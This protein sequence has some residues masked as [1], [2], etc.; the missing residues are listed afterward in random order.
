MSMAILSALFLDFERRWFAIETRYMLCVQ[1]MLE[2]GSIE[3]YCSCFTKSGAPAF[4]KSLPAFI[5]FDGGAR[6]QGR[7]R[8]NG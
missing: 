2:F 8:G 3:A 7:N 6:Q 4:R 5:S 1:Y